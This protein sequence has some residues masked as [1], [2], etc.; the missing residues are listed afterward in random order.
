MIMRCLKEKGVCDASILYKKRNE[1]D[2]Y[3]F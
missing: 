1:G 3:E 2:L